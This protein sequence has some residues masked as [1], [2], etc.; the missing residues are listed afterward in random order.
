VPAGKT[1]EVSDV[2][3][4]Y[5]NQEPPSVVRRRIRNYTQ[6]YMTMEP[7]HNEDEESEVG[8]EVV[9]QI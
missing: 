5:R 6:T 9:E 3:N 8:S 1:V 7:P 2:L 4:N